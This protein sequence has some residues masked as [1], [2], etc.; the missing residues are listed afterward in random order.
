M[1]PSFVHYRDREG[2]RNN[3]AGTR[4]V[5]SEWT[6]GVVDDKRSEMGRRLGVLRLKVESD[7]G[8]HVV[9]GI[10]VW[11]D[12]RWRNIEQELRDLESL[13]CN[14]RHRL[15]ELYRIYCPVCGCTLDEDSEYLV[16]QCLPTGPHHVH[17]RDAL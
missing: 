13:A 11:N 14:V 4:F 15:R 6:P 3:P 5:W 9:G 17:G 2:Y 8:N 12:E 7:L 1:S 10:V 16:R